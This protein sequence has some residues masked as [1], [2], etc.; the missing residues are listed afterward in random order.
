MKGKLKGLS[1]LFKDKLTGAASVMMF[2][3]IFAAIF[4]PWIAPNAKEGAGT[5]NVDNSYMVQ[6]G[7]T[8]LAQTS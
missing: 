4:G 2:I 7:T 1:F 8:C 6:D 3:F 5:A